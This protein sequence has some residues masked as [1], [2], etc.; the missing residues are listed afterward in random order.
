MEV[1]TDD[2]SSQASHIA[3]FSMLT[4]EELCS[5]PGATLREKAHRLG[6]E[7]PPNDEWGASSLRKFKNMVDSRISPSFTTGSS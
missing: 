1:E 7:L 6:L 5:H 2:D 4:W 3:S